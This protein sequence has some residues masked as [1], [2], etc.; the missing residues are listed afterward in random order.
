M[1]NKRQSLRLEPEGR[2]D[3]NIKKKMVIWNREKQCSE[4]QREELVSIRR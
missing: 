3:I 4:S 2:E 1:Q